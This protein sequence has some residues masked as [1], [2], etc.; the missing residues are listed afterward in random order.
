MSTVVIK[1]KAFIPEA[2][3][4]H[5]NPLVGTTFDGDNRGFSFD[6]SYRIA[7]YI[8]V[9][10]DDLDIVTDMAMTGTTCENVLKFYPSEVAPSSVE[11][12]KKCK[13]ASTSGIKV[14]DVK[15]KDNILYFKAVGA[16]S[17]PRV[18]GSPD[19]DY[20]MYFTV[21]KN[22]RVCVAGG[23]DGFPNYEVWVQKNNETPKNLYQYDHGTEGPGALLSPMDKGITEGTCS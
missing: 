6:G 10:L 16:A 19:I 1:I 11:T 14:E 8:K 15:V 4:P 23:H 12:Q 5:P 9:D 3:I 18:P 20:E 7:Q 17:N 13:K 21:R 22:G 2:T